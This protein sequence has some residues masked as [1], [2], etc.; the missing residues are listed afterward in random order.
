MGGESAAQ[1]LAATLTRDKLMALVTE[2][3]TAREN[4]E[5]NANAALLVTA[6]C[7]RLR[8]AAGR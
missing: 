6:Y 3:V 5:R 7:A 4:V 1:E 2:T 8:R